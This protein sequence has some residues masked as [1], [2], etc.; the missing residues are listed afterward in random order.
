MKVK[1]KTAEV[2]RAAVAAL[3]RHPSKF[4]MAEWFQFKEDGKR[5]K[6]KDSQDFCGTACCL[7]GQIVLN[8]GANRDL[9]HKFE[10]EC[11]VSFKD[12]F[13]NKLKKIINDYTLYPYKNV[14]QIIANLDDDQ[15]TALFFADYWPGQFRDRYAN[16]KTGKASVKIL[17]QRVEHFIE[18]GE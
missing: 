5:L 17:K 14:A 18:T 6:P 10:I 12:I 11:S 1:K 3:E 2:L 4:N 16:A 7:A 13:P 9:L 8:A 15:G